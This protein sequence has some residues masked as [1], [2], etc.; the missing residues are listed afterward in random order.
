M[1]KFCAFKTESPILK[2][3]TGC[4][5]IPLASRHNSLI[6]T[7]QIST[8]M[9]TASNTE[10][11]LQH[12]HEFHGQCQMVTDKAGK[13]QPGLECL[14]PWVGWACPARGGV[15]Y[16]PGAPPMCSIPLAPPDRAA[17]PCCLR[18]PPEQQT[19]RPSQCMQPEVLGGCPCF[20][21]AVHMRVKVTKSNNVKMRSWDETWHWYKVVRP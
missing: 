2:C 16:T 8:G 9:M 15:S 12:S 11:M 4:K 21:P 14:I 7:C 1:L 6:A 10:G 18:V 20:A 17:A 3:T 13:Q 5:H 19:G